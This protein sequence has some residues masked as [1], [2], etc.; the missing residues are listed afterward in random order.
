MADVTVNELAAVPPNVTA[1]VPVKLLPVMVTVVPPD[2]MFGEKELMDGG[3]NQVKPERMEVPPGVTMLTSPVAP[4]PAMAMMVVAFTTVKEL[5]FIPPNLT[6]EVPV[7]L[8]P[9]MVIV[10]PV[11]A[12]TGEKLVITGGGIKVKPVLVVT[13]P[14][15]VIVTLPEAPAPTTAV[16]LPGPFTTNEEAG[17]DPKLTALALLKKFPVRVT[18]VPWPA[19]VG[20]KND[21]AGA[22]RKLNPFRLAVPPLVIILIAPEV[23]VPTTAVTVVLFTTVNEAAGILPNDTCEVP[24]R[25]FPEMVTAVP[26]KAVAGEKEL[27][28]GEGR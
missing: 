8:F 21:K 13:P 23:P 7:K 27:I 17:T 11:A 10:W 28:T 19:D 20:E 24:A 5:A 16:M 6:C 26:L 14:G 9:V 1:V 22:K 18:V 2:P 12:A 25:L 3:A 4:A 15:V